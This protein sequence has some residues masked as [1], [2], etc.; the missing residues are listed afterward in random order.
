MVCLNEF[1]PINYIKLCKILSNELDAF[2]Q[3]EFDHFIKKKIIEEILKKKNK[4]IKNLFSTDH[5]LYLSTITGRYNDTP[6]RTKS[7]SLYRIIVI[8]NS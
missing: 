4:K 7:A 1:L 2:M 3:S 6:H 5:F 8:S